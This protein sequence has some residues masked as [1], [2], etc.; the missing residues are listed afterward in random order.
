MCAETARCKHM[1][2]VFQIL[3]QMFYANV[4]KID[5]DVTYVA[6]VV[7]ICY[8]LLFL[9]FYFFL[10]ICYKYVYL[11]VAYILHICC[12]CFIWMLRMF[13]QWF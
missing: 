5:C 1:F 11:D 3:L 7:H 9:M 6:M 10:N 4:A 2:Q 13:L 12:K 8:R